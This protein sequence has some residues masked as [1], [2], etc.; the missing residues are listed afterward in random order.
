MFDE[1]TRSK[2]KIKDFRSLINVK[3]LKEIKPLQSL[4]VKAEAYLEPK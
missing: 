4:Q 1:L 2:V 3:H